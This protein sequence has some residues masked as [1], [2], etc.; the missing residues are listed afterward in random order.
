MLQ[1][2]GYGGK[3]K[4]Q[5]KKATIVPIL[6]FENENTELHAHLCAIVMG[7]VWLKCLDDYVPLRVFGIV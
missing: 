3:K 7:D 2:W 6:V 5:I 1:W 4:K